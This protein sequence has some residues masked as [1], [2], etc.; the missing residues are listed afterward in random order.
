MYIIIHPF[1]F[2]FGHFKKMSKMI[3]FKKLTVLSKNSLFIN[4]SA[5]FATRRPGLSATPVAKIVD[6]DL[7]INLVLLGREVSQGRLILIKPFFIFVL[8]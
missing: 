8:F 1:N 3:I 2:H 4:G 5:K 6:K 7:L